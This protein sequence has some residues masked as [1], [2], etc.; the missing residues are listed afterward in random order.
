MIIGIF[1]FT[2]INNFYVKVKR[3]I[4][5]TLHKFKTALTTDIKCF[6]IK[7]ILNHSF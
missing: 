7:I 4:S 3:N 1:I 2:S 6:N 5:F